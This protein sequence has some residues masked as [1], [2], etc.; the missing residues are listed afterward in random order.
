MNISGPTASMISSRCACVPGRWYLSHPATV[1]V[2][3]LML[4]S[5]LLQV[6]WPRDGGRVR[7]QQPDVP[8]PGVQLCQ[9]LH[10]HLRGT[11]AVGGVTGGEM[12]HPR[13]THGGLGADIE[14]RD[15]TTL[16]RT[17]TWTGQQHRCS[18]LHKCTRRQ[19]ISD[20]A[21]I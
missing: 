12:Y 15:N 14:A 3:R 16:Y 9:Q 20:S 17:T 5:A 21:C 7:A 4:C 13:Q 10:C 19:C 8:S 6:Q 2:F 11:L 18:G 1:Y